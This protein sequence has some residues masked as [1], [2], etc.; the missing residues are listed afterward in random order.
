MENISAS[1]VPEPVS[2]KTRAEAA[3]A[4]TRVMAGQNL[5]DA[6]ARADE[7]TLTP[8]NRSLLRAMA[9]GVVREHSLLSALVARL[10]DKPLQKQPELH[11]LLLLGIHQLRS[12]RM[13]AHAAL[14]ETVN[15]VAPLNAG[16]ARGLVNAVLR[17]YQREARALENALPQ[18]PAIR[19]SHPAWLVNALRQDWP[20]RWQNLL[21][22]NNE[23]GP[24]TLRVNRR[25]GTVAGYLP[26]LAAAS[27][28][29]H[30][31]GAA[32][33]AVVLDDAVAVDGIPGFAEGEVSVQD[34]AAQLAAELLD[35]QTGQRVLDVCAAPGGKTAHLLERFDCD[36]V[37]VDLDAE[38]LQRV[39]ENLSR[40]K[41]RATLTAGDATRPSA[42]WDG[43]PF[44][45][46][47]L[48]APCS[49]TGVIR[50]HP[51]IKWLRRADDIPRLAKAQFEML[52][53][54]WPLL[55][56]GG[57]LLYAVC[58]VLDAEGTAV[59]Q[60]F[61]S[62]QD[63]LEVLPLEAEWGAARDPGRRLAPGGNFDGF[64]FAKLRKS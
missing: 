60:R 47:L 52:N 1:P 28:S 55:A 7:A 6:L 14:S 4:V 57:V 29:G 44:D 40:L 18:D 25:R 17:R 56:P 30:T 59:I 33:D 41:L 45:R 12:M 62:S 10:L 43:K 37:A 64:Y 48:D 20:E 9:Y 58:S 51:D 26:R 3:R 8:Q 36:V 5:D 34:A 2:A 11:A 38:R 61:V 53:A 23:A 16:W 46:I 63:G 50:R 39:S 13:P 27:L 31:V 24:L 42:W 49:S 35:V 22:A 15:A 21:A 54:L 32:A 19:F